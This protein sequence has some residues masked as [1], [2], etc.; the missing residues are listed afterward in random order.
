MSVQHALVIVCVL[1]A[2]V[3]DYRTGRIPNRWLLIALLGLLL[4]AAAT[5]AAVSGWAGVGV[6][7]LSSG[8]GL[9]ACAA[10]PFALFVCGA[11]GGGDVK[12]LAVC[13]A[14]LGPAIGMQ[15]ELYAFTF[16]ALF[17]LARCAFDGTLLEALSG[18]AVL[19]TN[20]LLPERLRKPVARSA[21][22]E[23]RFGP[24]IALG[25]LCALLLLHGRML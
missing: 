25:V 22:R 6:R 23:L 20:P 7:L 17:G 4:S 2:A 10:V 14:G 12:L 11:Q 16:G 24:A 1:V 19:I 13:G 3:H 9:F 18:S 8:I 5:G 21:L 15:A